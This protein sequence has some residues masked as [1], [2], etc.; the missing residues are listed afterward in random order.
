MDI[1]MIFPLSDSERGGP[2]GRGKVID[3]SSRIIIPHY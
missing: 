2:E 1:V 3:K